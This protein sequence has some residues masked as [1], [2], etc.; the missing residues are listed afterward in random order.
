MHILP[1][2]T[3]IHPTLKLQ[4]PSC[5]A[6]TLRSLATRERLSL[7]ATITKLVLEGLR[8]RCRRLP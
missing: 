6:V 5:L 3:E 4:L 7:S 2:P 1:A 8:A